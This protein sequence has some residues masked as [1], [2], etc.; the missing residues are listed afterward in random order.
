[1][2]GNCSIV[3]EENQIVIMIAWGGKLHFTQSIS[4]NDKNI[5]TESD[6]SQIQFYSVL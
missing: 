6:Q 5:K 2:I 3:V 1:M 4:H